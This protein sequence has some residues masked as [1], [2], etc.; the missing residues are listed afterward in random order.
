M[1][2]LAKACAP[3]SRNID[4]VIAIVVWCWNNVPAQNAV[5]SKGAFALSLWL[6]DDG[7]GSKRRQGSSIE[8]E[9]TKNLVVC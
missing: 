6:I 5:A 8:V 9:D 4:F 2:H 7:Y 3:S 1:D